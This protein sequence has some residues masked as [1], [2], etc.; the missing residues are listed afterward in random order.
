[1]RLVQKHRFTTN[2]GT[3]LFYRYWPATTDGPRGAIVLFHRGHEHSGRL[4]H[5]VDE[6]DLPHYAMFAWDA[7]G[8]GLSRN[9]DERAQP[10][11]GTFIKDVDS[12]VRHISHAY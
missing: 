1:M 5:V 4:E 9:N 2:D 7:R 3:S 12:F 10:T 8:H 6:M 11:L